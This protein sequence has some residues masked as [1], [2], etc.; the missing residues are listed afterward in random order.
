MQSPDT[1][2]LFQ[3]KIS[4][5][6][7]S[8]IRVLSPISIQNPAFLKQLKGLYNESFAEQVRQGLQHGARN[9]L[10]PIS[11]NSVFEAAP[12]SFP[13]L[14]P[15]IDHDPASGHGQGN[16]NILR[17]EEVRLVSHR[18]CLVYAAGIADDSAF[19]TRMSEHGC[20]VHVFDCT[21]TEEAASVKGK[22]F[23][24][25]RWCLG[26]SA[27]FE[28]N[29]YTAGQR[30]SQFVFKTLRETMKL[31]GHLD[32]HIDLIKLDIEGFEWNLFDN[33]ILPNRIKPIQFAFELHTE[34][35]NP[36]YVPAHVVHGK[37]YQAVNNLVLNLHYR[38]YRIVSK[39]TNSGDP[40]CA[41][42]V[43]FD[44]GTLKSIDSNGG[45]QEM[46]SS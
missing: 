38:G 5:S 3:T 39:E 35:A 36:Y 14:P 6:S 23:T 7:H 22:Q 4:H 42:F 29:T 40:A 44:V 20:E 45:C 30:A 46:E 26:T 9:G 33:D 16:K 13:L 43:L 27:S 11:N 25:H 28:E 1:P 37:G 34:K 8:K 41:E 12:I 18:Q 2:E 32:R 31:L 15:F 10:S 21:V 19:E 24:F 17:P